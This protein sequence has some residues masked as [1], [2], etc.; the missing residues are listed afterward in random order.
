MVDP[1]RKGYT[2]EAEALKMLHDL[3]IYAERVGYQDQRAGRVS[4][5]L[6]VPAFEGVHPRFDIEVKRTEVAR[7]PSWIR[8]AQKSANKAGGVPHILWRPSRGQWMSIGFLKDLPEWA[9]LGARP[10][11]GS[12]PG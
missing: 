11:G 2:G 10:G 5:D 7:L 1:R 12:T 6:I 3:G 4:S 8:Q 9:A